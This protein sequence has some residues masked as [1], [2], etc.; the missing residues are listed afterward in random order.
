VRRALRTGRRPAA[1]GAAVLAAIVLAVGAA[2]AATALSQRDGRLPRAAQ[3][4]LPVAYNGVDGWSG[5]RVRLRVLYVGGTQ[6]F[7]R[8][9]RWARWTGAV[10]VSHGTLWVD[11]C[12]PD[13][14]AGQFRRYPATVTLTRVAGHGGIRFFSRMSLRYEH[15]RPR[16][17]RFRWG[18]YPGATVPL[19]IGGP[20]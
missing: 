19:W 10:A 11:D 8:T 14:A 15:G 20:G 5:G 3:A 9:P 7:V 18:T 13:C 1:L 2:G 17:Y 12:R 6:T 16:D 4:R